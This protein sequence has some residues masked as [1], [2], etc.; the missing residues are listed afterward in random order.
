MKREEQNVHDDFDGVHVR[1]GAVVDE[2]GG[3]E[4]TERESGQH[5]ER[6]RQDRVSAGQNGVHLR[7][8]GSAKNTHSN[9]T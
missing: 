9:S 6:V 3:Q 4:A 5:A 7:E 1:L 2:E 8:S